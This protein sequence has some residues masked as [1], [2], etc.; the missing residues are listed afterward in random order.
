MR[1]YRQKRTEGERTC[2]QK[3]TE[4]GNMVLIII[5]SNCQVMPTGNTPFAG[6]C[7]TPPYRSLDHLCSTSTK[8]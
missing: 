5:D 4:E 8:N 7:A 6:S 1:T 2:R 3:R